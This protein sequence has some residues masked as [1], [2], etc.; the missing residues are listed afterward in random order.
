M[1]KYHPLLLQKRVLQQNEAGC[2][3]L[4]SW[5]QGSLQVLQSVLSSHPSCL[6]KIYFTKYMR[7]KKNSSWS[8][9]NDHQSVPFPAAR[10]SGVLPFLSA[11]LTLMPRI[12]RS[13]LTVLKWP[14]NYSKITCFILIS[15]Q[16]IRQSDW[17]AD[18]L[19]SKTTNILNLVFFQQ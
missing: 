11:A 12:F 5:W 6:H 3:H 8:M 13:S 7:K 19:K 18:Y 14:K 9:I 10:W 15:F 2:C 17:W 4:C 16:L 1:V